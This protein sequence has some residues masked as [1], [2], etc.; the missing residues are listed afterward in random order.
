LSGGNS[1]LTL[2]TS[3]SSDLEPKTTSIQSPRLEVGIDGG[4]ERRLEA[5]DPAVA[6]TKASGPVG[7]VDP[8]ALPGDGTSRVSCRGP[9]IGADR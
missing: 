7:A 4:R 8:T 9:E 2:T 1:E 3:W 5:P 6:T